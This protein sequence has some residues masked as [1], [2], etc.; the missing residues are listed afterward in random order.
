MPE[1]FSYANELLD[2]R[3]SEGLVPFIV[4]YGERT[5][6]GYMNH[7]GKT[8]IE[9]SEINLLGPFIGGIARVEFYSPGPVEDYGYIDKRGRFI[10][11]T[12]QEK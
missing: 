12:N 4:Y 1:F 8:A 2:W 7:Q 9:P 10:W 5:L 3:Y 11:R 6:H